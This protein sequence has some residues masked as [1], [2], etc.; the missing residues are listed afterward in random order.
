MDIE[1]IPLSKIDA[2]PFNPRGD[3]GTK[4]LDELAASITERGLLQP[5]KVRPKGR[6]YELVYGQRRWMAAESFSA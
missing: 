5:I 1:D 4:A 3:F 2:S 6:R